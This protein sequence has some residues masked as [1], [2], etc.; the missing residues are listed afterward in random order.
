MSSSSSLLDSPE[1]SISINIQYNMSLT[2]SF[3]LSMIR[4]LNYAVKMMKKYIPQKKAHKQLITIYYLNAL[5]EIEQNIENISGVGIIVPFLYDET[6]EEVQNKIDRLVEL[7]KDLKIFVLSIFATM[8]IMTKLTI[9][10]DNIYM[11]N[12]LCIVDM[13][14]LLKMLQDNCKVKDFDF[15]TNGDF[16]NLV[17]EASRK[18]ITRKDTIDV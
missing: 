18:E 1:H 11:I 14:S 3:R 13:K 2:S 17:E 7:K 16:I 10:R 6:L 5:S 15:V 12:V 8:N 4:F 9:A